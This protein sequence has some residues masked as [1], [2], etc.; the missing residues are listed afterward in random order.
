MIAGYDKN[1]HST[2]GYASKRFERLIGGARHGSRTVEDVSAVDD[3]V[4]LATHRRPERGAVVREEVVAATVASYTWPL[5]QIES[6]VRIG[7]E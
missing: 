7:D 6:D 3:N 5:R 1:R 4:H 2:R